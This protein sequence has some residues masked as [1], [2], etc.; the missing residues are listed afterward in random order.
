MY[1]VEFEDGR[2]FTYADNELVAIVGCWT[3][4]LHAESKPIADLRSGHW[5]WIT[6]RGK[7]PDREIDIAL[8]TDVFPP[9]PRLSWVEKFLPGSN[10][11]PKR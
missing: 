5:V 3:N 4:H 7:L 1:H 6:G 9:T 10:R 11:L 8:V 2:R